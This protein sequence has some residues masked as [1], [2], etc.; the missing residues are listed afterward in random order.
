MPCVHLLPTGLGLM[1]QLW[2]KVGINWFGWGGKR[3][4]KSVMLHNLRY[5]SAKKKNQTSKTCSGNIDLENPLE[6][7]WDFLR[8]CSAA[9][10]QWRSCCVEHHSVFEVLFHICYK[11]SP[12]ACLQEVFWH[13][14][15]IMSFPLPSN[16]FYF[17]N[18]ESYMRFRQEFTLILVPQKQEFCAWKIWSFTLLEH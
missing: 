13:C 10:K 8:M 3:V 6:A 12:A 14:R 17:R 9:L 2:W 5:S 7:K 18:H 11:Y 1:K 4:I 16:A 15:L